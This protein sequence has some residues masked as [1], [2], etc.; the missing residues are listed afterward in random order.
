MN[1][2]I[3]TFEKIRDNFLLYLKT[4]FWTQFP[5][6]ERERET[7]LKKPGIL[8]QEPWIEPLPRYKT[9]K[10]L[11][12]LQSE[13]LPATSP[14]EMERF[15]TLARCGLVGS[16]YLY[17]HQIQMLQRAIAG[18]N[19]VVTAGTGSG[20]TES[21]LLPLFASLASESRNWQAPNKPHPHVNDWWSN[22]NWQATCKSGTG[23]IM[24]SYRIPQ[25]GQET[26]PAAVRA[27]ILY[28][29]NAL[30]EDQLTRLRRALDSPRPANG[31]STG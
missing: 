28:P 15:K 22:Q 29:M 25:R 21:F 30:V 8:N 12:D 7:M 24:K 16:Y 3:G 14:D 20:K 17:T 2:P 27:L 1:D 31:V 5:G 10:R 19:A 13:D 9:G 11:E 18:Q 23:Q 4:A 6:L 26:R